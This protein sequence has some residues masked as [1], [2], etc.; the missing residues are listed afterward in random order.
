MFFLVA[1]GVICD[2]SMF[3]SLHVGAAL[4][5]LEGELLLLRRAQRR[6]GRGA[7]LRHRRDVPRPYEGDRPPR[8]DGLPLSVQLATTAGHYSIKRK[9]LGVVGSGSEP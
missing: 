6:H 3:P 9:W 1:G 8:L 7:L 2:F 5:V 4:P